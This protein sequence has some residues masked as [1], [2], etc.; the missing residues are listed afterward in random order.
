MPSA[1]Q[2]P[3]PRPAR[4]PARRRIQALSLVLLAL[5]APALGQ[6]AAADVEPVPRSPLEELIERRAALALT[7]D[8]LS[9]LEIIRER[10]ATRNE[11]LVERMMTLRG[12]WRRLRAN[13][14]ARRGDGQAAE[15][16]TRIRANADRL[17]AR[18]Q[19][20]NR[21]AMQAVNRLLTREQRAQLRSL[22]AERRDARGR[23]RSG[24]DPDADG[25]R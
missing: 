3:V 15:R 22:L 5:A 12:Q 19:S 9:R 17:R 16:L 6:E 1:L 20:N 8:Q 11:P 14:D 2:A 23:G 10:L 24:G 18:I 7:P 4:R 13:T 25:S 21:T